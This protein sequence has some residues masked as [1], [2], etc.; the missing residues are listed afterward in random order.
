[1]QSQKWPLLPSFRRCLTLCPTSETVFPKFRLEILLCQGRKPPRRHD[2]GPRRAQ[3]HDLA[4][5][6][7][8][9]MPATYGLGCLALLGSLGS[10]GGCR[11]TRAGCCPAAGC[12]DTG[13]APGVLAWSWGLV[14][15]AGLGEFRCWCGPRREA[16]KAGAAV[17]WE[18]A[19]R[20]RVGC[21]LWCR[22]LIAGNA[23]F[24]AGAR[25]RPESGPVQSATAPLTFHP[26]PE[27]YV[28]LCVLWGLLERLATSATPSPF[29]TTAPHS[30]RPASHARSQSSPL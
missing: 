27:R 18:A 22:R 10:R 24:A 21:G 29:A 6:A 12:W 3:P 17:A 8:G 26:F 19:A 23:V 11:M 4:G 30:R 25:V 7:R 5:G 9:K 2:V 20:L 1:V 13:V 28:P 16:I 14:L 15:R